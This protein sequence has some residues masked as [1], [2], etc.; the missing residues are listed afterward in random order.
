[1]KAI[2]NIRALSRQLPA[3]DRKLASRFIE[4]RDFDELKHLV[5]SAIIKTRHNIS[6]EAPKDEYLAVDLTSL[7]QLN[8]KI[9]EYRSQL[10]DEIVD[11][12]EDEEDEDLDVSFNINDTG[13]RE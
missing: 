12:I 10:I 7:E 2:D 9:D 3:R 6:S 11:D 8:V 1:M 4:D 5:I 13:W